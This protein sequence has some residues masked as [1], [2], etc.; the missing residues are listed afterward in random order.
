MA[1]GTIIAWYKTVRPVLMAHNFIM[2]LFRIAFQDM[3]V[4]EL[5]PRDLGDMLRIFI[6]IELEE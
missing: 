3:Y 1:S 4:I 6:Q 5:R 2:K